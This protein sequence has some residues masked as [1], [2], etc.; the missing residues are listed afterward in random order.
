MGK[1]ARIRAQRLAEAKGA[2]NILKQIADLDKVIAEN[3]ADL[4]TL[5][6]EKAKMLSDMLIENRPPG[7]RTVTLGDIL[8]DEQ[9]QGVVDILNRPNLDDIA[10]TKLLK[11]YLGKPEWANKFAA[12]GM[13]PDYLAYVL[14]ANKDALRQMSRQSNRPDEPYIPPHTNN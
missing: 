3:T 8:N 7:H 6:H 10:I 1:K 2:K 9:M 13:V 12:I 11:Q 14:L 4:V 5:E